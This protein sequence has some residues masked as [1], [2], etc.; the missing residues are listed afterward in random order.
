MKVIITQKNVFTKKSF[1]QLNSEIRNL[2]YGISSIPKNTQKEIN[3]TIL[4]AGWQKEEWEA[5]Y[6]LEALQEFTES[7]QEIMAPWSS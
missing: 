6:L 5:K 4:R 3:K 1:N 7:F 2:I